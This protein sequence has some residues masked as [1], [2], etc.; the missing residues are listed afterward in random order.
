MVNEINLL[1]DVVF[2]SSTFRDFQDARAKILLGFQNLAIR[3][4]AMEH[5]DTT[6]T[7]LK[8][9]C[10]RRLSD[11]QVYLLVVGE[12]YG[13][14]DPETGLSYTELEYNKAVE[15]K[16]E[17]KIKDIWIFKPTTKYDP[18]PEHKDT[19]IAKKEKLKKF[20]EKVCTDHTP[21]YYD[22]LDDL[23]AKIYGRCYKALKEI[24]EPLIYQSGI[25][26]EGIRQSGMPDESAVK[27]V[28]ELK[29]LTLSTEEK[30]KLDRQINEMNKVL[31]A[32]GKDE[33]KTE[34]IDVK[35]VTLVG[36]YYYVNEQFDKAVEMYDLVLKSFPDDIRAINNKGSALRGE[37]NREEAA[38]LWHRAIELDPNYTDPIVNL[39]GVLCEMGKPKEALQ[40]LDP[41]YKKEMNKA[42]TFL[43]LNLGLAHS[44]I[45]NFDLAHDFYEKAEKLA[46]KEV[47][48]LTN[49]LVLYQSE[50]NFAKALDYANKILSL[51]SRNANALT[52]KGSCYLELGSFIL[53]LHYLN[54]SLKINPKEI[55]TLIN[56]A[57]AYRRMQ[58]FGRLKQWYADWVE[59]FA[60]KA[61]AIKDDEPIALDHLGWV[62]NRCESYNKALELFEK[63]LR[64]TPNHTGI[65]LDKV[66]TLLRI[67]R[68]ENALKIVD[69]I[70][71][72]DKP[73]L[74]A[75]I[76]RIKYNLLLD[77]KKESDAQLFIKE[78]EGKLP[79]DEIEYVKK[80]GRVF[81]RRP[82]K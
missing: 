24:A 35:S 1:K 29:P 41:V 70:I 60:Q 50:S 30:E 28:H 25:S 8:D 19:E 42:D 27:F 44:K 73:L 22:N 33:L 13:S 77:M 75:D 2:F 7:P 64:I 52:A 15:L 54:E 17:N 31:K 21:Q 11:S 38:K 65:L 14:I 58:D 32:I 74:D 61:L 5:F 78:L 72:L 37:K 10:L 39:G 4:E 45:G 36:N 59:L 66:D 69:R 47:Q 68:Y 76:L 82:K 53:G 6:S 79:I 23:R 46:P 51:E 81:T 80:R 9:E 3:V 12:M 49:L 48:V 67:D 40:I 16:K 26:A 71:E 34:M 63:A 43:L 56:L 20:R 18:T 62:M 55:V 57:L